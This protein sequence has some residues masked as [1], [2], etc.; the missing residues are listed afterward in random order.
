[1]TVPGTRTGTPGSTGTPAFPFDIQRVCGPDIGCTF[2]RCGIVPPFRIR[3]PVRSA[4]GLTWPMKPRIL[5]DGPGIPNIPSISARP[6]SA[7]SASFRASRSGA[8]TSPG[9]G[10]A[11]R[12]VA[13]RR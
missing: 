8:S 1:M 9:R 10:L 3:R 5:S 2:P 13:T 7:L 4:R 6:A 11:S 12:D